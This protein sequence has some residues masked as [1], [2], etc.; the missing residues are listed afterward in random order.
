MSRLVVGALAAALVGGGV[1]VG[2][3]AASR[4]VLP[5]GTFVGVFIIPAAAML[6]AAAFIVAPF[7]AGIAGSF[8]TGRPAGVIASEIGFGL[9]IVAIAW[10][11]GLLVDGAWLP[12]AAAI[13]VSVAVGHFVGLVFRRPVLSL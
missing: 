8:V 13:A 2:A 11:T 4:V 7:V 10:A 3:I 9:A 5:A 6:F 1:E 12:V